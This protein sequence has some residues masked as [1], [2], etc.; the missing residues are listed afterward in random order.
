M[1]YA[2]RSCLSDGVVANVRHVETTLIVHDDVLQKTKENVGS[3]AIDAAVAVMQTC[4]GRHHP[5][6]SLGGDLTDRIVV[7]DIEVACTVDRDTQGKTKARYS[8]GSIDAGAAGGGCPCDGAHDP[9]GG[10]WGDL[11]NSGVEG[12]RHV[13]GAVRIHRNTAW[14]LEW[15]GQLWEHRNDQNRADNP[16]SARQGHFSDSGRVRYIDIVANLIDCD[17]GRA[18]KPRI[19]VC[20]IVAAK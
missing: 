9:V 5:I 3:R 19:T 13:Q 10:C 2:S 20:A 7:C 14:V 16:I 6:R 18:V 8:V 4:E 17:A 1:H 11:P 12:I 15:V